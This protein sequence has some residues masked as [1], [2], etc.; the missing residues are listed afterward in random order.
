MTPN[1]PDTVNHWKQLAAGAERCYLR[2]RQ[3]ARNS[4]DVFFLF[5]GIF[6][7]TSLVM[8]IIERY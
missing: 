4:F 6:V 1:R 3:L 8:I 2:C 5:V 7:L